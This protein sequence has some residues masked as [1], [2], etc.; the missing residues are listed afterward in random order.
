[1]ATKQSDNVGTTRGMSDQTSY[2]ARSGAGK[3]PQTSF[4]DKWGMKD[5]TEFSGA[6]PSD[7][8]TGPDA[9][10]PNPLDPEPR[11]KELHKQ[12]SVLPYTFSAPCFAGSH[13]CGSLAPHTS[14]SDCSP[15]FSLSDGGEP[16]GSPGSP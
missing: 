15:S 10:S 7:P 11:V 3:R 12:P 13:H 5:M 16:G 2:D 1:M 9:S 14:H 6:G 8:G 4:P